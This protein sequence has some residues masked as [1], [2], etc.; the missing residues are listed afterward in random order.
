VVARKGVR[1]LVPFVSEE[2]GPAR[3]QVLLL[4]SDVALSTEFTKAYA[5]RVPDGVSA[6]LISQP[7]NDSACRFDRRNGDLRVEGTVACP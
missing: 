6:N 3:C 2:V 7:S 1:T 5:L 4:A